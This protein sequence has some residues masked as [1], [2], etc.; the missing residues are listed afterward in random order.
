MH[1]E[2]RADNSPKKVLVIGGTKFIG[3]ALV[4]EPLV[5]LTGIPPPTTERAEAL[6]PVMLHMPTA[7]PSSYSMSIRLWANFCLSIPQYLQEGPSFT[8]PMW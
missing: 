3:R 4:A 2:E 5:A 8:S 1:H 6:A 7:V